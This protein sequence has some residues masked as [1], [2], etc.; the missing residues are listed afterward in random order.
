MG[1]AVWARIGGAVLVAVCLALIAGG[2]FRLHQAASVPEYK[3]NH[4]RTSFNHLKCGEIILKAEQAE[5]TRRWH[6][7]MQ[8]VRTEKW[9]LFDQGWSLLALGLTL[10]GAIAWFRLFDL[11]NLTRMTTPRTPARIIAIGTAIWL[12]QVPVAFV[13]VDLIMLR[14]YAPHWADSPGIPAGAAILFTLA[15]LPV[16][17]LV[18]W[19]GFLRGAPLPASLWTWD[20]THP[21]RSIL[22]SIPPAAVAA[23]LTYLTAEAILWRGFAALSIP[24]WLTGVWLCLAAR[25]AVT[26]RAA[27]R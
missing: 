6:Q 13:D 1:A 26:S 8:E 19:F 14:G 16:L 9:P 27:L 21:I 17:L 3:P 22:L 7:S 25:A 23:L 20:A 5:C 2:A 24:L 18:G 11:R 10:L 4:D 15:G 12:A